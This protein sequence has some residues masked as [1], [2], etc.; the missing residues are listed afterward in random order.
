MGNQEEWEGGI[1][2]WYFPY[3]KATQKELGSHEARRDPSRT[4]WIGKGIEN[5]S[6]IGI[7]PTDS[8]WRSFGSA[9]VFTTSLREGITSKVLLRG[10]AHKKPSNRFIT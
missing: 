4:A 5:E 9:R 10:F 2:T 8:R 1:L 7:H 6:Y 3:N